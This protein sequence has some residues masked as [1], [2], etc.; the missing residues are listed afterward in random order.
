L[1]QKFITTVFLFVLL[2]GFAF[3]QQMRLS[4][5][6]DVS[7]QRSLKKDQQYWAVGQT[8]GAQLNFS[9]KDGVYV[10]FIYYS[11]GN[12]SNDVA[13]TAKSPATLPPQIAYT[14]K[15]V[16]K[17]RQ[18][19]IGWK[20]YLKEDFASEK[21]NLYGLVGFGLVLGSAQSTSSVPVDTS[22]YDMPVLTGKGHFKRLTYDLGLGFEQ[23]IGGDIFLYSEIKTFIPAT[24][25]PSK[26]LY[27]N[28]DAPLTACV[29]VGLRILF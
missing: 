3:S 17:Y 27:V 20:H 12:V 5:A 2:S 26:Y 19:S 23:P 24:D 8:I 14:S 11:N 13:A 29:N 9:P 28:E 18:L 1:I 25:Y 15:G 21:W 6:S 10:W 4:L 22:L 16:I 7:V